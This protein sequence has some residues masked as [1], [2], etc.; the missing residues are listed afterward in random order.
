MKMIDRTGKRYGRLIVIGRSTFFGK[1]GRIYWDCLCDCGNESSV[2]FSGY[3]TQSCGCKVRDSNPKTHGGA[4]LGGTPEYRCW[5]NM[6]A[7]CRKGKTNTKNHGDRGIYVCERWKKGE[8][9]NTGFECFLS[10]MGKRPSALYSIERVNNESGYY[11]ENCK[12]ATSKEQANNTRSNRIVEFNGIKMTMPTLSEVSGVPY[13]FIR[14]R[15]HR[16]GMSG[17]DIVSQYSADD[18]KGE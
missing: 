14:Y 10:D 6:L 18:V 11:P 9:G 8:D 4:V 7:R 16:K 12:W 13:N 2:T 15:V 17:D 3:V 1:E 5:K